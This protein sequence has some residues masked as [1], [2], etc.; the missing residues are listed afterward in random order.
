M[1][2]KTYINVVI[3]IIWEFII[4]LNFPISRRILQNLHVGTIMNNKAKIKQIIFI[5]TVVTNFLKN[6]R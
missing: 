5:D 6:R 1:S 4:F 3:S 2:N